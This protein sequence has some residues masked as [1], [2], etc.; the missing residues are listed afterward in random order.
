[1]M[2]PLQNKVA[3]LKPLIE[4]SEGL[5]FTAYLSNRGDISGPKNQLKEAI[6]QSYEWLSPVM[7][8][9]ERNRFLDPLDALVRDSKILKQ[10]RG[11]VGVFRNDH[12][13]RVINIPIDI[14]PSCQVATSFHVKPLLKWIQQDPEFL[15]L[16]LTDDAAHLYFGSLNS[17]KLIDSVL[18][19]IKEAPH[20][21]IVDSQEAASIINDWIYEVT[22]LAKPK[23]FMMGNPDLL[24]IVKRSLNYPDLHLAPIHIDSRKNNLVDICFSIR[25]QLKLQSQNLIE[26]ALLE[27]RLAEQ[28]NRTRK[29]IFQIARAVVQGKVR[30]LIITDELNIYGKIDRKSGGLAIHPFDLDHEDDDI[31]DDLAQIVLS[32][33]GQIVIASRDQTPKGRPI[34]AILDEDGYEVENS[35]G[36]KDSNFFEERLG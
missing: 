10:I 9:E 5:H 8:S 20:N 11:N 2:R 1:M 33:G 35:F 34:L 31:L 26:S 24:K 15:L 6:N 30:K 29:N 32:K 17:F 27:Y 18:F 14:S 28:S 7:T 21:Y 3:A 16:N 13:I 4:S 22:Q 12:S 23:L 19:P 25:D 36:L